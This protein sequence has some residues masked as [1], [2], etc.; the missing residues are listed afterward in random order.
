MEIVHSNSIYLSLLSN[1][2][3]Q[4]VFSRK[5]QFISKK[6]FTSV[7]IIMNKYY[8]LLENFPL[9]VFKSKPNFVLSKQLALSGPSIGP[10]LLIRR[11]QSNRWTSTGV[12]LFIWESQRLYL[13]KKISRRRADGGIFSI[14]RVPLACLCLAG[15]RKLI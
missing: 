2:N 6:L 4:N 13:Q 7:D 1:N 8:F 5:F 9:E 3:S 10:F 14:R 15:A 11:G 12:M